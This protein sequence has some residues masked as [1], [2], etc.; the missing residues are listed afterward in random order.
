MRVA[1]V[2]GS[3]VQHSLSPAL[4]N[5]A[6]R[7]PASTG[8]TWRSRSPPGRRPRALDAMRT[9]GL[10]GLSVTTPHKED[11][12]AAVDELAPGR[13]GAAL[14]QHGRLVATGGWSATAPT[15]TGSSPRSRR[16]ASS[17][18]GASVAV[19]GAGA[20]AR[21]VVDAL[22]RAGGARRRRRQPHGRRGRPRPPRW[23]R[24]RGSAR[25]TTSP[26]PTS[27]STPRRSGWAPT[28]LP[29]DPAL[30]RP[31]QVVADLVYHPLEHGAAA[32]RRG[33][34]VARPSTGS[35]CSSTRPCSSSSCGP[36]CRP[37]RPRC[38]PPPSPSSPAAPDPSVSGDRGSA[39]G[40]PAQT[41][42]WPQTLGSG[43]RRDRPVTWRAMLRYLTAGESHGQALV[44]IVE[45]LPAGLA[46][47]V[48]D[49]QA[50]LA[51]RRLGY[52][53]GPRQRFEVDEL[54]LLGGVRHGRTLGSP[55]AIEIKNTEWFRSDKWHDE[56]SPA[57]GATEAPLTQVRPGHA[58]LAGMQKYG[59]TDAR[60]VLERASA[61]ETAARVAAGALAKLL[62]AELGVDVLSHVVQMGQARSTG[63]AADARGPGRRRRVAG[64]LLR[65]RR[66]RGDDPGDQGRGQGRRLA[67]RRRRGARRRRPGRARQPRPLG[68]QARRPAGPGRD[69][70]PGR[71][72][73]RDRRRVRGRRPAGERGPRPDPLGRRRRR[74]TGGTRRSPAA[75][76]AACRPASCSSCGRR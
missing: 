43:G 51:R 34:G 67:R 75:S 33:R 5:A 31:G 70:H 45:G 6:F 7:P 56:M 26:A 19:V 9:L 61:R 16:R 13:G 2:I 4:H 74:A 49:I 58:D 41:L 76:R 63:R 54:T 55:V 69:E 29:F 22:G 50:E 73:R 65:P 12:A 30:L 62:L 10:G 3:P 38:A 47:T 21:S 39:A 66:G 28:T 60:D 32:G 1:A 11:V 57:P 46:V 14:R 53:R 36:A 42:R 71:Q 27:S 40:M 64:A 35:G 68:P 48:E 24:R 8:C 59:F 37:T 18:G 17:V 52:G 72:G 25:P 23:R 15:A 44:V 20:A